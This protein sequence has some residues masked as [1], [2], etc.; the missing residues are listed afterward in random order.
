MKYRIC[1]G[2]PSDSLKV[3]ERTVGERCRKYRR[4]LGMK[5]GTSRWYIPSSW[6]LVNAKKSRRVQQLNRFRETLWEKQRASILIWNFLTNGSQS[7]LVHLPERFGPYRSSWRHRRTPCYCEVRFSR[8]QKGTARNAS[9]HHDLFTSIDHPPSSNSG[10]ALVR[11]VWEDST[12]KPENSSSIPD[13]SFTQY[14]DD[15]P[16]S[17]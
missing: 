7:K 4:T 9:Y 15:P 2:D 17:A 10:S 3:R 1:G 8:N 12:P 11:C 16:G 13:S 6:T 5:L 14:T